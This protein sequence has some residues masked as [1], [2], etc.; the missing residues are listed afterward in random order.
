MLQ[1]IFS[2]S[3][4]SSSHIHTTFYDRH[5]QMICIERMLRFILKP[6]LS[7]SFYLQHIAVA[8]LY[9]FRIAVK[10]FFFSIVSQ[11]AL[12]NQTKNVENVIRKFHS[13][14]MW[15]S[16]DQKTVFSASFASPHI[17]RGRHGKSSSVLW[18]VMGNTNRMTNAHFI[19]MSLCYFTWL[20]SNTWNI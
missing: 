9:H 1:Y 8:S 18:S 17:Q 10:F 20:I 13:C 16:L 7:F 4:Y 14:S 11:K 12:S 3:F 5:W 19:C 2:F 15:N 6:F